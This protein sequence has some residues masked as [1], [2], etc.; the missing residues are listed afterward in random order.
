VLDIRTDQ[1]QRHPS[2]PGQVVLRDGTAMAYDDAGEGPVVLAVH[3][4]AAS[5]TFFSGL[6]GE[7]APHCRLVMPDLRAHGD[8]P[9]GRLPL[10]IETLADDLAELI[11]ALELEHVILLGWSMGALVGWTMIERHGSSKLAGLVIEDMSP[12]VLNDADW[13]L[14]MANGLDARTSDRAVALMREDWAGYAT[15][16]APRMFAR[17][18]RQSD[19]QLVADVTAELASRR[20]EDMADIWLSMVDQDKRAL[21]GTL[22]LPVLIAHGAMSDAYSPETSHFLAAE[23][24]RAEITE[25]ARSGHAPH[26]EQPREFARAVE[27]FVSRVS[28][29]TNS[30]QTI[31]G[32]TTS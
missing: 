1:T 16:F 10:S 20:G 28:P 30:Q 26:L 15:S 13:T 14:G 29:G 5:R 24:P 17:E 6:A 21:L 31:E 11:E 32:S 12:R 7:L 22:G 27:S 3:G 8:T 23:L 4:W 2:G 9:R 18:R 25:F 19:P